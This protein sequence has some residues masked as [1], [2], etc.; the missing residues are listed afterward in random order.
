MATTP[1]SP[2]WPRG[3]TDTRRIWVYVRDDKP[4]APPGAAFYY[5]RDR[6]GE[7]P[8]AHLANY[9]G[10]FPGRRLRRLWQALRLAEERRPS[11][12]SASSDAAEVAAMDYGAREDSDQVDHVKSG[13]HG[14]FDLGTRGVN[15]AINSR[16]FTVGA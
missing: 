16:A 15:A 14:R 10:I 11:S 13:C 3:K 12:T 4:P 8:Q 2:R 9:A 6:A 1:R 5:S 7:H